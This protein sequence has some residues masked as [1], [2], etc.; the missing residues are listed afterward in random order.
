MW[1]LTGLVAFSAMERLQARYLEAFAPAVCAVLG[2]SLSVLWHSALGGRGGSSRVGPRRQGVAGLRIL[3]GCVGLGL[4]AASLNKDAFVINRART[5]SLLTDFSTPA[6]SRYLRAHR[7]GARYEVVGANINDVIGLVAPTT[8]RCSSS[9]AWTDRSTRTSSLQAQV[10][11]GRV[12]FYF[13]APHP[14]H[15]GRHCPSNQVWA[16]AHSTPVHGQ[17]GLRRF[18]APASVGV[19][20]S[21]DLHHPGTRVPQRFLGLSFELSSLS[22]IARYGSIGDFAT[23]LRSLGP[24]VLALRW[25]IGR[26]T[27]RLDGCGHDAADMGVRGSA[28]RRA[29]QSSQAREQE[30]LAHLADD[31]SRSL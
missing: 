13:V 2:C 12:R 26:H 10:A 22:Q 18:M 14:C 3:L 21:I 5:D 20:V 30:R 16:Y 25:R 11:Q 17:P 15:S 19:T 28:G 24:G 23:M 27:S 7:D 31:R 6:L 9:T 1:F 4:L 8:F 29:S